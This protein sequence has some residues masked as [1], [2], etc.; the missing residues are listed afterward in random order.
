MR[1]LVR[2][3]RAA[4]GAAHG[5]RAGLR[6]AGPG[7]AR[8]G[9]LVG[10]VGGHREH[11][12]RRHA[13]DVHPRRRRGGAV[14]SREGVLGVGLRAARARLPQGA[15]D[16]RGAHARGRRPE[17]GELGAVGR[18]VHRRSGAQRPLAHR[19]RG[20]VRAGRGRGR[21]PGRARH[22]HGREGGAAAARGPRRTQGV[23]DRARARR[24]AITASSSATSRRR[25]A[26]SRTTRCSRSPRWGSTVERHYGAPQDIEWAEEGGPLVPRADA[27]DHDA[28][29]GR[30][31]AR[32][33]GAAGQRPRRVA[34]DRPRQGPRAADAGRGRP[35]RGRRDPRRP[36]DVARL[37]PDDPP[38]RRARHRQRRHHLPRRDREPR[39]ADPVR[40]RD[41]RRRPRC[42]ATASWS[43]STARR[44]ASRRAHRASRPRRAP[45]RRRQRRPRAS[46]RRSRRGSTSTSRSPTRP[47]PRPRCPST[48]SA[49]CAPSS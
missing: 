3:D 27:A 46:S 45:R 22:L 47:R 10:D 31:R 42:C 36:D 35:A 14:R 15:E 33:R 30:A 21:R 28:R 40:G 20:R 11:V 24:H 13:R 23:P 17:D 12:V 19:H 48:A 37:G 5:A 4:A 39:A 49:C 18:D 25:G 6:P 26:C 32:G 7:R 9:A 38:R 41:A 8:G 1:E 43:P 29:G 34:G 16:D 2:A 44:G